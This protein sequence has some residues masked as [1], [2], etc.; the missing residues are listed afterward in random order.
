[1]NEPVGNAQE[2]LLPVISSNISHLVPQI[3]GTQEEDTQ[4]TPTL[5]S[6]HGVIEFPSFSFLPTGAGCSPRDHLMSN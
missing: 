1:M 2:S 3:R 4:E 5:F 6:K